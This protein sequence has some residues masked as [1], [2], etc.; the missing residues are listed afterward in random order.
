MLQLLQAQAKRHSHIRTTTA[1]VSSL[2]PIYFL[3]WALNVNCQLAAVANTQCEI[4]QLGSRH[5]NCMGNAFFF[6]SFFLC[7]SNSVGSLLHRLKDKPGHGRAKGRLWR[8]LSEGVFPPLN[9]AGETA[10]A[11]RLMR[12]LK[13]LEEDFPQLQCPSH[14]PPTQRARLCIRLTPATLF[15]P[16]SHQPSTTNGGGGVKLQLPHSDRGA[17]DCL[18][19]PTFLY[20]RWTFLNIVRIKANESQVLFSVKF[21]FLSV[22]GFRFAGVWHVWAAKALRAQQSS[23]VAG[24][25]IWSPAVLS[26]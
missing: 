18:R 22:C 8:K 5:I 16:S 10:T 2:P 13:R 24:R 12:M 25:F 14:S 7:G 23:K 4:L 26:R 17:G 3:V 9:I 15:L 11:K 21:F 20:P 6:F 19:Q 1:A